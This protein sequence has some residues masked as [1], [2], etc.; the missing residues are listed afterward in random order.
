MSIDKCTIKA[1]NDGVLDTQVDLNIGDVVQAGTIVANIL[2]NE[3]KYKVD[4]LINDKDIAT[5][6][7]G[8]QIKYSFPSLPYKEYGFL[9]GKVD[10]ISADS[11][12]SKANG[13]IFYT[14]EADIEVTKVYSHKGEVS[15]IKN[16]M[17]CE[18]QIVT[19]KEKM[20]YYFYRKMS[21]ICL[22]IL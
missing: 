5:I 17:T 21:F 4:L 11:K 6:K 7:D 14:A 1:S 3:A 16:G 8:Q 12:A 20:L 9:N 18:A 2:P 13:A 22:R 15:E 10:K 19:R